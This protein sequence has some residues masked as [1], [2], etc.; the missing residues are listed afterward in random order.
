[1]FKKFEKYFEIEGLKEKKYD[2]VIKEYRYQYSNIEIYKG[3]YKVFTEEEAKKWKDNIKNAFPE[4]TNDFEPISYDWLGRCFALYKNQT[5][6]NIVM[7]EI[8]T[9]EILTIPFN[10][11][12]FH[13]SEIIE[14]TEAVLAKNF[15][16]EWLEENAKIKREMCAGYKVPLFLNGSD[17]IDNLENSDMDV[18][19]YILGSFKNNKNS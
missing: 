19:W 6:E 14:Q 9:A 11:K 16:E 12:E 18:Y 10:L 1:M 7:F 2:D 5:V 8:G 4:F 13:E 17:T 15:Y 3:L